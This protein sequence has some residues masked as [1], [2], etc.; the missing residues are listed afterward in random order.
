MKN[1]FFFF[2]L[3]LY[4][5]ACQTA[6]P[7]QDAWAAFQKCEGGCVTEVLAVKDA[8]L[9]NPQQVL[10]DFQAT[11]EKGEDHVIGWLY[12]LRDSVLINP[13]MGTVDTRLAMQAALIA[14]A[15]TYEKDG[16]V[17]AMAKDVVDY[18]S[19]V[20]VK[21]GKIN[22]PMATQP[23]GT[24]TAYCY[25]FN[26]KGESITCHFNVGDNG[27]FT[28]YYKWGIEGK[29]GTQGIITGKNF[30]KDTIS[31]VHKYYQEGIFSTETLIF[32][33]KGDVF[34]Q[35]V[36]TV[37]DKDGKMV[38]TNPKDLKVGYTLKKVDCAKIEGN[39]QTIRDMEGEMAFKYPYPE[40]T[41]VQDEK[42]VANLQGEWQSTTDPKT[43]IKFL[44]GKYWDIQ[45]GQKIEPSMRYRYF[46]LCP[47][48]CNPVAKMPCLIIFGQDDI[49]YTLVKADGKSLEISQIGGTGN[50]NRYVKKK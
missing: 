22:D 11:Y 6:A 24:S 50:T 49:C 1:C 19:V 10:T 5:C 38:M 37:L 42:I 40:L 39:F 21:A 3:S 27:A 35:L 48:D 46:P 23:N 28:G 20:D 2:F 34:T 33:K 29:D 16:K 32:L 41:T 31:C 14:A 36:S 8:L 44:K 9:K 47:K 12:I 15:K 45:A 30:K 4:V 18:L 13:K 7:K 43:S 25:Q 26:E 17:H